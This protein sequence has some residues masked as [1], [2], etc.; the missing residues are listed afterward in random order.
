MTSKIRYY[1]DDNCLQNL[2]HSFMQSHINYNILNWSCT[3]PTFLDP[4][5]TKMKKAI[6]TISFSKT[7]YDHTEPLFKKH[8]ILPFNEQ[9]KLKKATLLWKITK[10]YVPPP[11]CNL[12]TKKQ[13]NCNKSILP[14]VKNKRDKML[15]EYSCITVWNT[16]PESIK[17]LTTLKSFSNNYKE[18]LLNNI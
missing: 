14:K 1:V 17:N 4:L 12:F 7:K 2:Y 13:R 18:H 16:V 11:V 3:H 8:K 6:H 5:E 10:G 15:L 9:I